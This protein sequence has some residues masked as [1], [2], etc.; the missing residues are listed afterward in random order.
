MG[1]VRGQFSKHFFG[2]IS[3]EPELQNHCAVVLTNNIF[4]LR[5]LYILHMHMRKIDALVHAVDSIS[6]TV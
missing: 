2:R 6:L 4:T 3:T 1:P 5:I